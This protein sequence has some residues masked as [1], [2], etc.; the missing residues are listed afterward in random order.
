MNDINKIKLPTLCTICS[1]HMA[2]QIVPDRDDNEIYRWEILC[3]LCFDGFLSL[4]PLTPKL[5][6][7]REETGCFFKQLHS[8]SKR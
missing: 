1:N 7:N 5:F 6:R 2:N 3:P 8:I 4:F